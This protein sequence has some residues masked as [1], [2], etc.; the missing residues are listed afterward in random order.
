[1]TEGMRG[2]IAGFFDGEG[3]CRIQP[4][5][6][7]KNGVRYLRVRVQ[8]T[9][10]HRESLEVVKRE[11]GYGTI[12]DHKVGFKKNGDPETR[13]FNWVTTNRKAVDFLR[14]VR[15]HLVIKA[16]TVDEILA[17]RMNGRA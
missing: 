10:T 2:W 12:V 15:P 6:A 1:M 16:R 17:G 3:H 5:K 11:V 7:S 9:N 13:C 4:Y 8:I 14:L